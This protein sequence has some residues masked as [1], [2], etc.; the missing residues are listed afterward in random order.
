MTCQT[1][2]SRIFFLSKTPKELKKLKIIIF[3]ILVSSDKTLT[4]I[5][6]P[7]G[8]FTILN[9]KLIFYV[10][11]ENTVI[12]VF[13]STSMGPKRQKIKIL[14]GTVWY[15]KRC[16]FKTISK[17]CN[18]NQQ[19]YGRNPKTQKNEVL[20]FDHKRVNLQY[21]QKREKAPYSTAL[22]TDVLLQEIYN[23]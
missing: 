4:E 3:S 9:H 16:A 23:K 22:I 7:P 21:F 12:F 13:F 1:V 10:N 18:I 11:I 14:D 19:S 6:F 17:I 20:F 2:P 15:A 5:L 8:F